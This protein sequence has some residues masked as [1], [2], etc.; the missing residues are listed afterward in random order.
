M[1]GVREE[2]SEDGRESV[3]GE[4]GRGGGEGGVLQESEVEGERAPTRT[5]S[6]LFAVICAVLTYQHIPF[7]C[8]VQYVRRPRINVGYCPCMYPEFEHKKPPF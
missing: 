4:R 3:E 1:E 6:V 7:L 2:G 8:N 5:C